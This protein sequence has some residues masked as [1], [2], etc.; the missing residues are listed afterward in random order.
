MQWRNDTHRYGALTIGLHWLMLLLLAAVYA[1]M[2]L[3]GIF[4]RGSAGRAAMQSAHYMLG[5]SV[6]ALVWVRLL[7]VATGAIPRI[8]PPLPKAQ[9]LLATLMKLALYAFM[10]AMPVLGWL[11]L[12]A[13]GSV[14][15]FYGLHLPALIGQSKETAGWIK[16]IHVTLATMGYFLIG[17]HAAAAL[18]HHYVVRDNTLLRMLPKRD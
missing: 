4:P 17:G 8:V 14:I 11:I 6:G 3:K 13:R 10:L 5:L 2:E 9:S 16:G 7:V 15:P 18:F 12:S 1:C